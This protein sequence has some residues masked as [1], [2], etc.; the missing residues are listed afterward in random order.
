M[1]ANDQG[2]DA[3]AGRWLTIPRTLCFVTH[4]EDVL[5]LKR[6]ANRRVFP[7]RYN[8]VGG[9]I[10]RGEDALSG[11][12]REIFEETGL[13]A[14][15]ALFCGISHIDAGQPTGIIL[16]IFRAEAESRAFVDSHEGTLE[17]VPQ[18]RVT[19][20]D[21][22]E[23][24]PAILPRALAMN[25]GDPPFFVHLSYDDRDQ[26]QLRFGAEQQSE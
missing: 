15:N 12:L 23:D 19:E 24:L 3:T 13:R 16:M 1:G 18:A 8:G 25:P 9:H 5:L 2:A 11:A 22:V 20:Y 26:L 7:N 6:A 17:W 21:L 4:G 10:E 14:R